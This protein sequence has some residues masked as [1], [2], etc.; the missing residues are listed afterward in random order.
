MHLHERHVLYFQSK[1]RFPSWTSRVRT[2]SPAP[3]TERGP[4]SFTVG[5]FLPSRMVPPTKRL[6]TPAASSRCWAPGAKD[7]G[8]WPLGG[9]R[10][11]SISL[12]PEASDPLD[13]PTTERTGSTFTT[14]AAL[15]ITSRDWKCCTRSRAGR[16]FGRSLSALAGTS[17][18]KQRS[19]FY[20]RRS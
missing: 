17:S 3:S 1:R 7:R 5:S 2:P 10:P 16:A 14:V 15:P 11:A 6:Q 4:L 12:H 8:S 18:T 19:S 9:L 20:S 13:L